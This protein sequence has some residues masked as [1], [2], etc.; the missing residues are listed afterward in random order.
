MENPIK[1]GQ[2]GPGQS[3]KHREKAK[4]NKQTLKAEAKEKRKSSH[5][6]CN[7]KEQAVTTEQNARFRDS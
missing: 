2:T 5:C 1:P 7:I 4:N 3:T 6:T